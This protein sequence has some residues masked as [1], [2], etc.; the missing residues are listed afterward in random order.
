MDKLKDN[1]ELRE[2]IYLNKISIHFDS[3]FTFFSKIK[4]TF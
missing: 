4:G 3:I 2:N 1:F